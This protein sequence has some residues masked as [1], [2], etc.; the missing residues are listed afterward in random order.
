MGR[1]PAFH[2]MEPLVLYLDLDVQL[3]VL[4]PNLLVGAAND[5]KG[6]ETILDTKCRLLLIGKLW[7]C[8][9]AWKTIVD[10]SVEYNPLRLAQHDYSMCPNALLRLCL[11]HEHNLVKFFQLNFMLF[12][13]SRHVTSKI[14]KRIIMSDLRDLS[15][16]YL[17]KL[18]NESEGCCGAVE[19][20]GMIFE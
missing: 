1:S 7:L 11:P 6:W 12:S 2:V 5:Y 9:K 20:Y 15:L 18:R 17:A 10:R 16:R 14:S 4:V 13:L 19:I 8:C 3:S